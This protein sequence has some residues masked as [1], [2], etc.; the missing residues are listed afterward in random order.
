MIVADDASA[1]LT[2]AYNNPEA[3]PDILTHDTWHF[4][5][6]MLLM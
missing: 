6:V 4:V 3:L 5:W 2:M 1:S